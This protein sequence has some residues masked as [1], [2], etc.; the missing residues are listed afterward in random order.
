MPSGNPGKIQ[1]FKTRDEAVA[2]YN[3]EKPSSA[4]RGK[5]VERTGELKKDFAVVDRRRLI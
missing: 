1:H 2:Y 3:Q 5:E 4:G